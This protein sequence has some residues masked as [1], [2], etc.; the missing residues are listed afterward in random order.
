MIPLKSHG[1]FKSEFSLSLKAGRDLL[2]DKE[3]KRLLDD[4]HALVMQMGDEHTLKLLRLFGGLPDSLLK[5]LKKSSYLKW[6]YSDLDKERQEAYRSAIELN[7]NYMTRRDIE[8]EP[9]FSVEALE[10][11]EVGF[12]IV[13]I[14]ETKEKVVSWYIL[15]PDYESPIWV[16]IVNASQAGT[17]EYFKAHR[18]RLPMLKAMPTSNVP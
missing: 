1:S 8:P 7:V 17:P 16:T 9:G 15:L 14:P 5:E 3:K 12:A 6:R 18:Q 11:A 13:T 2:T 10:D 4:S